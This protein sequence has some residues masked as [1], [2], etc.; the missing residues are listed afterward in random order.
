MNMYMEEL[1]CLSLPLALFPGWL[2]G[3]Q[4]HLWT[5]FFAAPLCTVESAICGG[6]VPG[7]SMMTP[8]G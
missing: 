3:D 2:I 5:F 7:P 8:E 6:P 1:A 4:C